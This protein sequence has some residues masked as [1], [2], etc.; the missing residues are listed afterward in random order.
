VWGID[1]D[2]HVSGT[3]VPDSVGDFRTIGTHE[4]KGYC[5]HLTESFYIWW[6]GSDSWIISAAVG[7]TGS[8]YHKRTDPNIVG[9]YGPE[10]AA[11]GDATVAQ[12]LTP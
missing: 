9:V 12:G 11:T 1:L 7:T 3:I 6:D 10:G 2:H 5:K 8:D 4:G